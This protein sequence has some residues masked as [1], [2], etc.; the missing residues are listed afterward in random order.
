MDRR[1]FAGY[2]GAASESWAS[3]RDRIP[4]GRGP[5]R[6][7]TP[8]RASQSESVRADAQ[9]QLADVLAPEELEQCVGEGAHAALDDVLA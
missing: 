6:A 2:R 5:I 8:R 9:D 1:G 3:P 7:L 4:Y